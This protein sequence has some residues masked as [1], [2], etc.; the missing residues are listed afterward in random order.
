VLIRLSKNKV[1]VVAGKKRGTDV[2]DM[3]IDEL[4][5]VKID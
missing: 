1:Q 2:D 4:T 5:N 3:C